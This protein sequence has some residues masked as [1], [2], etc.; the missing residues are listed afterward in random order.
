MK[1]RGLQINYSI[2]FAVAS[3]EIVS[4]SFE[5][6]KGHHFFVRLKFIF[7][8]GTGQSQ[9]TLSQ[10]EPVLNLRVWNYLLICS[11]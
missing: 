4:H 3:L 10:S 2:L 5:Q 1:G 9:N 7:A 11:R 6:L 8:V